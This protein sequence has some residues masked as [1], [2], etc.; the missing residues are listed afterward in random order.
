MLEEAEHAVSIWGLVTRGAT[1]PIKP[2][3][4]IHTPDIEAAYQQA[5][6]LGYEIVHP[7]TIEAQTASR[8]V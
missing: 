8:A 5:Q 2:S 7:L 4:L 6:E 1:A 3:C